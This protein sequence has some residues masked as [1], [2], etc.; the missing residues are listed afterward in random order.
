MSDRAR[1]DVPVRICRPYILALLLATVINGALRLQIAIH[2]WKHSYSASFGFDLIR[3]SLALVFSL[4]L[5]TFLVRLISLVPRLWWTRQPI[6][7][8]EL[9]WLGLIPTLQLAMNLVSVNVTIY[10]LKIA[11]Y[12]LLTESVALYSAINL[13][14]LFWYWYA[15]Y[16]LRG[17]QAIGTGRAGVPL[18]ILFPEEEREKFLMNTETWIPKPVDYFYFTILSSNCFGSPEGHCVIGSRLKLIQIVHT[19]FMIF[20]FIIIVARAINTLS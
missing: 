18:G 7:S 4:L 8:R 9:F 3:N 16:P 11:S 13:I 10:R 5:I 2:Y 14:F 1:V 12:E 19:V 20:V 15:D 17:R 6:V